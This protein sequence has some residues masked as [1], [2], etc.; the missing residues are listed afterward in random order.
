MKVSLYVC[1]YESVRES[2]RERERERERIK[3]EE[4]RTS[5]MLEIPLLL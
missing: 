4:S 2:A 3:G 5:E 1:V